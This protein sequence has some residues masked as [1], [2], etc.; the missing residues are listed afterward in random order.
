M[1]DLILGG[2]GKA[3]RTFGPWSNLSTT[4]R[5]GYDQRC[6]VEGTITVG[7]R[8]FT[9]E[10]GYGGHEILTLGETWDHMKAM[11]QSPYYWISGMNE[12]IQIFLFAMPGAGLSY[13]RIYVDGL[14]VPF[15]QGEIFVNDLELWIDPKTGMQIPIRWHVNMN[16]AVGIADMEIVAG[17]RGLFCVLTRSGYTLRYPFLSRAKGHI[18]LPDMKRVSIDDLMIYVEWGRSAMPLSGGAM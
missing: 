7:G 13:G 18:F 14:E 16:S 17:G 5:A 12:S 1:C 15:S 4:R 10:K 8:E 2:M 6:W 3:D 9:L 11:G